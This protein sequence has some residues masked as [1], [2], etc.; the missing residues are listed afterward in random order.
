MQPADSSAHMF[1]ARMLPRADRTESSRAEPVVALVGSRGSGK[2]A[3]LEAMARDC[4]KEIVHSRLDFAQLPQELFEATV[5]AT[6]TTALLMSRQ[7]PYHRRSPVFHRLGLALLALTAQDLPRQP[8]AARARIGELIRDYVQ[9]TSVGRLAKESEVQLGTVAD[10][11]TQMAAGHAGLPQLADP[12]STLAKQG[13]GFL[14]RGLSG[15][16]VVRGAA[17]WFAHNPSLGGAQLVDALIELH[18]F[19][20]DQGVSHLI[21]ALLTDMA[22]HAV[23]HPAISHRCK[24]VLPHSDGDKRRHQHAWV[25]LAD[26]ADSG[27]GHAFL[28]ELTEVRSRLAARSQGVA[29]P[30]LVTA[31]YSTWRTSW[32]NYWYE[33]WHVPDAAEVE[34][35]K[36]APVPPLAEAVPGQ[37]L[38]KCAADLPRA[39]RAGW[40]PVLVPHLETKHVMT[41]VRLREQRLGLAGF[42]TLAYQLS[43]GNPRIVESIGKVA[44]SV[45]PD[46]A[47]RWNSPG[48]LM[49]TQVTFDRPE[50]DDRPATGPLWWRS[51]DDLLPARGAFPAPARAWREIPAAVVV[52]AYLADPDHVHDLNLPPSLIGTSP[53][54]GW[55]QDNLWVSVS[56][57]ARPRLRELVD[58]HAEPQVALHPW[59]SRCLLAG[60][61]LTDVSGP[62]TVGGVPAW[63]QLFQRLRTELVPPTAS[64]ASPASPAS[65]SSV[66]RSLYY[67]LAL[68]R[69]V[70]VA[71]SLSERFNETLYDQWLRLLAQA[72]AAPCRLLM[73]MAQRPALD[74][75]VAQWERDVSHPT[76][77]QTQTAKLLALLWLYNDPLV[78]PL[79]NWDQQIVSAFGIL[80]ANASRPV[81]DAL[82]NARDQFDR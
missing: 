33:P 71:L 30:L 40:F 56:H 37:W 13:I 68:G 34:H 67:D 63:D 32:A 18:H 26:N 59:L 57:G 3:L 29:D 36:R 28:T 10:N 79:P 53:L 25:L 27:A 31:A 9:Q 1:L 58:E 6:T 75:L 55:F 7:W 69:F 22:E 16:R 41:A 5:R 42:G 73:T 80:I 35:G 24:C 51:L 62:D 64:S 2:T 46:D 45:P 72:T 65:S 21:E 78:L 23:A 12:A 60:L 82:K 66:G 14:L 70:E 8:E 17:H 47:A 15:R 19:R 74:R 52:A 76:P 49:T 4:G 81:T 39:P 11:V 77:V 44:E 50:L 20:R 38:A 43:A 61:A 48:V 54:L